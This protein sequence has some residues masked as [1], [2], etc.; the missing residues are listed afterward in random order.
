MVDVFCDL[1]CGFS[2][3]SVP[4]CFMGEFKDFDFV[5]PLPWLGLCIQGDWLAE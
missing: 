5:L 3:L 1:R 2:L 4:L